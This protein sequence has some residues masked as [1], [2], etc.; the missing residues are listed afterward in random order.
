MSVKD[1]SALGR[2]EGL[3]ALR[4]A[5]AGEI[6]NPRESSNTASL[7]GRLREVLRDI[8]DLERA[9]PKGS[10]VDDLAARRKARHSDAAGVAEAAGDGR[11]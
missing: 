7:A 5:L 9:Q 1:Q 8:A 4:D 10:V 3:R 6:D 2:L 11:E